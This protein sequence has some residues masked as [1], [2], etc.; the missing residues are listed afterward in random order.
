[1]IQ[2]R[3][4]LI[5]ASEGIGAAL[6]RRLAQDGHFCAVTARSVDRLTELHASLTG[7]GHLVLPADVTDSGSLAAAHARLIETWGHLDTMIYCAGT[8]DPM[9]ATHMTLER[10]EAMIDVN[11]TGAFRAVALVLPAMLLRA[12]GRIVLMGS[13]AGYRGL[14]SA[15][16]Y[17]ASKA[18]INHLAE[19][20]R[21]DLAATPLR[22]QLVCPGFVRT[23]LTDKNSF[24]MPF[25]MDA[26][27]AADLIARGLRTRRFEIH[28]PK[29]L[30]QFLKALSVLPAGVYFP[31]VEKLLGK[32]K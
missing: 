1:M 3:I 13:V 21:L 14:G 4:W 2:E 5:G 30:S 7:N 18:G 29:R 25:L 10:V 15:M 17:G 26:D 32:R 16:G 24:G 9:P 23:R 22:V 6:A 27:R 28:F 20:L 19:N 12:A 11:L 8:Y 31:L